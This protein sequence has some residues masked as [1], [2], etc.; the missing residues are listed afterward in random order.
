MGSNGRVL[1]EVDSHHSQPTKM[2]HQLGDPGKAKVMLN[3]YLKVDFQG[4]VRMMVV[5]DLAGSEA[6]NEIS[7]A[8]VP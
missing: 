8:V 5:A 2:E 1:V 6:R 7:C 3:W 4:L